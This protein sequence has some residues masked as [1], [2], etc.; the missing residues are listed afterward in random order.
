M[1][2]IYFILGD[3]NFIFGVEYWGPQ[4]IGG[5]IIWGVQFFFLD[6]R[7]L[8]VQLFRG[9]RSIFKFILESICFYFGVKKIGV[10]FV[11]VGPIFYF[12]VHFLW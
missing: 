10:N 8:A 11:G 6:P 4:K 12:G 2:P 5:P 1:G 3:N 7:K 9:G